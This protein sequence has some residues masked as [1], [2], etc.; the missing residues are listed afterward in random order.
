MTQNVTLSLCQ[1]IAIVVFMN[2]TLNLL[3]R[4]NSGAYP[5]A[6]HTLGKSEELRVMWMNVIVV[7]SCQRGK[8]ISFDPKLFQDCRMMWSCHA[9]NYLHWLRLTFGATAQFGIT[10]KYLTLEFSC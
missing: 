6:Q 9:V 4:T 1:G 2:K 5:A 3:L 8:A 10:L 7:Q